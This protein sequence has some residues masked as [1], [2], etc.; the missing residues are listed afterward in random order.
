MELGDMIVDSDAEDEDLIGYE[1]S[2]IKSFTPPL[3]DP[4]IERSSPKI[5]SFAQ[6]EDSLSSSSD[7]TSISFAA[8][9]STAFSS[10]NAT[11][12]TIKQAKTTMSD[13]NLKPTGIKT[14]GAKTT[15]DDIRMRDGYADGR[16]KRN[17][18]ADPPPDA[19]RSEK[20]ALGRNTQKEEYDLDIGGQSGEYADQTPVQGSEMPKMA[21]EI[22][23][24]MEERRVQTVKEP[25]EI[26]YAEDKVLGQSGTRV[27]EDHIR[28]SQSN[29]DPDGDLTIMPNLSVQ[30]ILPAD[31]HT[32]SKRTISEVS[33]SSDHIPKPKKRKKS[34]LHEDYTEE[35]D[36]EV[37]P[38]GDLDELASDEFIDLPIEQYKP[39]PSRSRANQHVDT[40]VQNI[41][42]SIRPERLVKDKLQGKEK[43]KRGRKQKRS[44]TTLGF[45][46]SARLDHEDDDDC[47][48]VAAELKAFGKSLRTSKDSHHEAIKESNVEKVVVDANAEASTDRTYS[49]SNDTTAHDQGDVMDKG[50]GQK[51][52]DLVEDLVNA[53][54]EQIG[55]EE[56]PPTK[57]KRGRP[58]RQALTDTPTQ[59]ATTSKRKSSKLDQDDDEESASES[60]D[61]KKTI[62]SSRRKK[63][64]QT[65]ELRAPS[66]RSK[67]SRRRDLSDEEE[68]S[69]EEDDEL[70]LGSEIFK[71][72]SSRKPAIDPT[73][74]SLDDAALSQRM[75]SLQA[76]PIGPLSEKSSN[77]TLHAKSTRADISTTDTEE[78]GESVTTKKASAIEMTPPKKSSKP[79]PAH[80]PLSNSR[81][82]YRIGLSRNYRIPSLLRIKR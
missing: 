2:P 57:K 62:S 69:D 51:D 18:D 48:I 52:D 15:L 74:T 81:V 37:S 78:R 61:S 50:S 45:D 72:H 36:T 39:R 34:N 38:T 8:P 70:R 24:P 10:F 49:T 35:T 12:S 66:S 9:Y 44:K 64:D 1:E 79:A 42:Y 13:T 4:E 11:M 17:T 73:N 23:V 6:L 20:M 3:S 25:V 65:Q 56:P 19:P 16:W 76:K 7:T 77:P 5:R 82:P 40:L 26:A 14:Y 60:Y 63:S 54:S 21:G 43:G 29:S 80:S 67:T 22:S 75:N 31:K 41:D 33:R 32:T 55:A 28:T 59:P 46:D 47:I 27:E 71:A 53:E 30:I 58:K 68:Q